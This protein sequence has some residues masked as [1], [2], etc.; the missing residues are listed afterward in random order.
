M[1]KILVLAYSEFYL[2]R[3]NVFLSKKKFSISFHHSIIFTI[4]TSK[5][6][7]DQ[8]SITQKNAMHACRNANQSKSKKLA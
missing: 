3:H 4:K 5:I 7:E 1:T 2:L 6:M 8:V